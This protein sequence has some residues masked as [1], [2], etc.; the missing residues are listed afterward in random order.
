M[1][2]QGKGRG[3][4]VCSDHIC[5]AKAKADCKAQGG[6]GGDAVLELGKTLVVCVLG[7][8]GKGSLLMQTCPWPNHRLAKYLPLPYTLVIIASII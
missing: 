1:N 4:A 7:V 5:N 6:K 2:A 3:D 8:R